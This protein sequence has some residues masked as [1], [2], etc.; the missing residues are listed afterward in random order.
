MQRDFYAWIGIN[1]S[2]DRDR[3]FEKITA[4]DWL[5]DFEEMKRCVL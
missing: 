4:G 3:I 1:E 5:R 2:A